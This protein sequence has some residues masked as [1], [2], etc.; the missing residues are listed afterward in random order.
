MPPVVLDSA[1]LAARRFVRGLLAFGRAQSERTSSFLAA[2]HGRPSVRP[3]VLSAGAGAYQYLLGD[4]IR[5]FVRSAEAPLRL[6]THDRDAALRAVE[7]GESQLG[8]AVLDHTPESLIAEP[9]AQ[10][11]A[12][13]VMSRHH[14]LARRR[15]LKLQDL[16]G[17]R[18]IVPPE[19]RPHR[20]FLSRA[21][22]SAD[23]HWEPAIEANGWELLMHFARLELGVAVVNAFCVPPAGCVLRALPA[24]PKVSYHL[25]RAR[26]HEPDRAMLALRERIVSRLRKAR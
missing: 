3:L 9:V 15:T 22:M 1:A 12:A 2:L 11:G 14:P 25:F 17:V 8:V 18:L 21:L 16:E 5:D 20:T 24:I 10:V 7:R 13:L 19:G 6:M 23:I 4:A 26:A